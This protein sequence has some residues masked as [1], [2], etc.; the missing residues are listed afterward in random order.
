MEARRNPGF[1]AV[2]AQAD[3][4]MPDG[5]GL[6][7]A[8]RRLGR[9]LPQRVTGSDS[10]PLIAQRV[11]EQGWRL[12]LLGAAPGV[13][14]RTAEI[15]AGRYPGLRVSAPTPARPPTRSRRISSPGFGVPG[16]IS[17]SWRTV[18]PGKTSGSRSTGMRWPCR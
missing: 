14:E 17:S 3:I 7:W 16:P 4:C 12:Y 11:A 2:L 9:S 5:V 18:R 13:A 10:V 15:L 8:A 6:L 1:A